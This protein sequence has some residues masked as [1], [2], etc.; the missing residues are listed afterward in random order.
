MALEYNV[1]DSEFMFVRGQV[2][3]QY[4]VVVLLARTYHPEGCDTVCSYR[5]EFATLK[6]VTV[7]DLT[8]GNLVAFKRIISSTILQNIVSYARFLKQSSVR[9]VSRC[10]SLVYRC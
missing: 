2:A 8:R 6:G 1:P 3:P 10:S 4:Q 7:Y 9:Y 5:R